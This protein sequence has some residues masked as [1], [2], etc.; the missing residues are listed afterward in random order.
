MTTTSPSVRPGIRTRFGSH[1]GTISLHLVPPSSTD[2]SPL[3]SWRNLPS[4]CGSHHFLESQLE[5][6]EIEGQA[7]NQARAKASTIN[8][9][10]LGFITYFAVAAGPFGVEDAVRDAEPDPVLLAV[11]L[12]PITGAFRKR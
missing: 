6:E 8:H 2:R 4:P 10:T 11:L 12:V 7:G 1:D 9:I 5:L 3:K